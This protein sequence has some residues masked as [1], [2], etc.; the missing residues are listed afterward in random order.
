VCDETL[1]PIENATHSQQMTV[2][3]A[4]GYLKRA[5]QI[6]SLDRSPESICDASVLSG[7][8]FTHAA[9]LEKVV[10]PNEVSDLRLP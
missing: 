8:D 7:H 1:I 5:Q 3:S 2:F 6:R 9:R 4:V 10:T